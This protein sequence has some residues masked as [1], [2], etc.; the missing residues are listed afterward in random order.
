MFDWNDLKHFPAGA[1]HGSTTA[2][3]RAMKVDKST[4]KRRLAELERRIGKPLFERAPQVT[5]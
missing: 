1:R 2:P 4:V 3:G 5:S